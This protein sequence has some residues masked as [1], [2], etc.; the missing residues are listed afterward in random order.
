[1][2]RLIIFALI[3]L[4]LSIGIQESFEYGSGGKPDPRVCGDRLCSE[5]PGGKV[6]FERLG[7][8][9][10][11]NMDKVEITKNYSPLKQMEEG[12]LAEDVVCSEGKSLM[13]RPSD[14]IACVMNPSISTLELRDWELKINLDCDTVDVSNWG[15]PANKFCGL[16][17][18]DKIV[19]FTQ[20]VS[21][22]DGPVNEFGSNPKDIT[23]LTVQWGDHE[24]SF[25]EFL[26]RGHVDAFL[27]VQ[28]NDIVFEEY[29]RMDQ[30]DRHSI[31]SVTKTTVPALI[32]GYIENGMLDPNKK[33][34]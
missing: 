6:A 23:H 30:N 2:K 21:R 9:L 34:E 31:Q 11:E 18:L 16:N 19:R 10:E 5:V 12:I 32:H 22:G 29:W 8:T 20:V 3:P 25:D 28:G 7:G 27:V 14:K 26:Y 17:N 13:E 24:S 4:F 33:S 1:M 15:L